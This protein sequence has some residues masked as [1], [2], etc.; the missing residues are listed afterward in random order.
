MLAQSAT[1]QTERIDSLNPAELS[2]KPALERNIQGDKQ[3]CD[4]SDVGCR[5]PPR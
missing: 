1:R 2:N 3:Q 4:G 5:G